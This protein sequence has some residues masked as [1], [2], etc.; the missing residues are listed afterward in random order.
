M[1][2]SSIKLEN[3]Q[4]TIRR[5]DRL[6]NTIIKSKNKKQMAH[7]VTFIDKIEPSTSIE[8]E[9]FVLS[10]KSYNSQEWYQIDDLR[11]EVNGSDPE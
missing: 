11:L 9:H 4:D 3:L 2:Q 1:G 8:K 5:K 7:K 6:G 10:Y